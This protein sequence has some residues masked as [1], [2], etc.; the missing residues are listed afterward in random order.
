MG[1]H[2]GIVVVLPCTLGTNNTLPVHP[3]MSHVP[4][5]RDI[6]NAKKM[7]EV[8]ETVSTNQT[9]FQQS[10]QYS[11]ALQGSCTVTLPFASVCNLEF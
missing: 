1:I 11:L 10:L 9:I 3:H 7:S 6:N 4:V 2:D 8:S 5:A